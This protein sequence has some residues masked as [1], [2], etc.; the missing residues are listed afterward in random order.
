[1]CLACVVQDDDL[2]RPKA[3]DW[4]GSP[5]GELAAEQTEGG[6]EWEL[7]TGNFNEKQTEIIDSSNRFCPLTPLGSSPEGEHSLMDYLILPRYLLAISLI[8]AL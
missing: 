7:A 6:E 4:S 8:S 3:V 5:W 1:M 2:R